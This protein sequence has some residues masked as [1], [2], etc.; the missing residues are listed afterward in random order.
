MSKTPEKTLRDRYFSNDIFKIGDIV[1]DTT[2]GEKMKILDRGSN[3]VTVASSAGIFKKWLNEITEEIV[4]IDE[5]IN[6]NKVSKE[7]FIDTDFEIM[8]SGQL[9]IFGYETR[10][11]NVELSEFLIEQF[12]EFTDLYSKHQIVKCLDFALH[13]SDLSRAYDLLEKVD[14]F[15]SKQNLTSPLIVEIVKNDTERTRIAEILATVAGIKPDKNNAATVTNSVKALKDK[16][17]TRRQWEV[18]M[19]FL[20]LA[21]DAG[22]TGAVQNLPYGVSSF[23]EEQRDEIVLDVFEENLDLVV[24]DLEYDDIAEAFEEEDFDTLTIEEG[25]SIETRNKLSIKLKQ[26]APQLEVRRERALN[27]SA[28]SSVLMQRA[29]RL[30]ETMMKRRMFHKPATEMS[31]QEKERFE[32][33][34]GKR[35]AL[36]A[37]LAQRLLGKVRML[38]TAR[39]HHTDTP[40]SHTHD[41][42]TANIAGRGNGSS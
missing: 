9:K 2:S 16:Y 34:A 15:Y 23:T 39:L 14:G 21:R 20:I 26:H 4:K 18:L 33:G 25:L 5:I 31:R 6:E 30:A 7:V 19:P 32:S 11:F 42:A 40:V 8:E 22:L 37:K 3:Y 35:R 12:S 36:I 10:N 28:S 29:R 41:R 1:E 17:Q 27:K 24:A 13:E 38:Q